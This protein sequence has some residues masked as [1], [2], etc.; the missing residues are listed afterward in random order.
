MS[1]PTFLT[2]EQVE[3]LHRR[4]LEQ[5]GGQDVE[6]ICVCLSNLALGFSG[7]LNPAASIWRK[8]SSR[9]W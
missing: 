3:D 6:P 8:H 7:Q 2:L 9:R 4:A 5:H 1:E